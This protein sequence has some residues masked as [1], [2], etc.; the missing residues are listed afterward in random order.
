VQDQARR[1]LEIETLVLSDAALASIEQLADQ[2]DALE[3][4]ETLPD[5]QRTAVRGRVLEDRAY[6][7]LAVELRCSESVVRQ[8]VSRGLRSLRARMEQN[9]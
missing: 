9:R 2:G 8:R 7:E 4:L 5:D 3:L 1:R 6:G